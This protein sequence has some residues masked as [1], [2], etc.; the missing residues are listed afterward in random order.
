MDIPAAPTAGGC[1]PFNVFT[2]LTASFR[3]LEG[4]GQPLDPSH[5]QDSAIS[6]DRFRAYLLTHSPS[7]NSV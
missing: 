2:L 4:R 6:P 5:N 3:L 7:L 1:L